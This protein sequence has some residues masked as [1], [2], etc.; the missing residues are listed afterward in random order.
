MKI[1]VPQFIVFYNGLKNEADE[2][3]FH[4]SDMFARQVDSPD[5]DLCVRMLNINFGKN[6][7]LMEKCLSLSQYAEFVRRMREALDSVQEKEQRRKAAAQIIDQAIDDGIL[8]EV[9]RTHRN[10]V[11]EMYYW[12]YDEEAHHWAIEQDA[13]EEGILLAQIRIITKKVKKGK[14]LPD[15]ID[16]LESDEANVKPVWK[17]VLAEAPDYDEQRI[18]DRL[19]AAD[20][21]RKEAVSSS[22]EA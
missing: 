18:L 10:E 16:D 22:V 13:K 2:T 20:L 17:A 9:L 7:D 11:V 1:P 6:R 19:T 15:I 21:K 12:E 4:L 8:S 3:V 14:S 5:I